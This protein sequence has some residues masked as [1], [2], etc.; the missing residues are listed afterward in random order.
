MINQRERQTYYG[1]V[2]YLD[3]TVHLKAFSA[4]NSEN[5]VSFLTWLLSLYPNKRLILLWDGASSHRDN[6]LKVF[7][8]EINA[9]LQE[10]EWKITL[11]QF[12]QV[13]SAFS[14]FLD[15]FLLRSVKFSWY[16]GFL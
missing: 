1:A 5:T 15:G 10:D 12:A 11:I 6:Q 9:G 4:G 16:L 8:N 3:H 13:K 14:Q 2:N 7:L